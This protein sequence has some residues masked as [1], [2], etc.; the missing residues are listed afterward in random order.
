MAKKRGGGVVRPGRGYTLTPEAVAW[1]LNMKADTVRR[2]AARGD[3][4]AI[5]VGDAWRIRADVIAWLE[6]QRCAA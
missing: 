3:L 2:I 5:K 1:M 6:A 4:P